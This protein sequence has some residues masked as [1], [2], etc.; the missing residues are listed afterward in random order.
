[1]ALPKF[2]FLF[3]NNVCQMARLS[4]ATNLGLLGPARK[5]QRPARLRPP[6]TRQKSSYDSGDYH[7]PEGN[8]Y[9]ERF[10]RNL[11]EEE[12]WTAEYRS[13]EEARA[14]IA[15]W[16]E[17]YNHD[18]PHRGVEN[19]TPHE[20][21]LAFTAVLNSEALTEWI[22]L[23]D[24]DNWISKSC[25]QTTYEIDSRSLGGRL[26]HGVVRRATEEILNASLSLARVIRCIPKKPLDRR[27]R[28]LTFAQD[29]DLSLKAIAHAARL[30]AY[31]VFALGN[32]RIA[33]K[34]IP[35]DLIV[36]RSP[37]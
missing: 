22:D 35:L 33:N 30:N 5:L 1:M 17:E 16:I 23:N 36:G 15:R 24:I 34:K 8:S 20:A 10:H 3:I 11:K 9:I 29:I 32:R 13:L 27:R 14:S 6:H 18:R 7:H 28:I 12:I 21:F 31:L 2:S 37:R 4:P 25:L 26:P 19:R